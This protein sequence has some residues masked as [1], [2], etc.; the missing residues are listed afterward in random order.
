MPARRLLRVDCVAFGDIEA[1]ECVRNRLMRIARD[2]ATVPVAARAIS[3]MSLISASNMKNLQS[4]VQFFVSPNAAFGV[5]WN[6][7][8]KATTADSVYGRL[9]TI[10]TAPNSTAPASS[11]SVKLI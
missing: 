2:V 8:R 10:I 11:R 1:I 7:V 9:G 6:F 3:E 4:Y 5:S